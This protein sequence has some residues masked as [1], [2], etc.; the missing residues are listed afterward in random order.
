M[1]CGVSFERH[2]RIWCPKCNATICAACSSSPVVHV[3]RTRPTATCRSCAKLGCHRCTAPT[4]RAHRSNRLASSVES[5]IDSFRLKSTQE[6]FMPAD[7]DDEAPAYDDA[8][9]GCNAPFS[10]FR[11]RTK[12][13][14][15]DR[16]RC[17]KCLVQKPHSPDV[18]RLC[19]ECLYGPDFGRRRVGIDPTVV[20]CL[21]CDAAF[22]FFRRRHWCRRCGRTICSG[23]S[24][25][26]I[27]T[28][29]RRHPKCICKRCF[30]PK[31]FRLPYEL[32]Q[33]MME[34]V[35]QDGRLNAN[36]V[37][38]RFNRLMVMPFNAINRVDDYYVVDTKKDLLGEGAFGMVYA[39]VCR[40]TGEPRAIKVISKKKLFTYE[41]VK[42]LEREISI[43]MQLDH[44]N[45]VPLFETM[46][47]NTEVL[48]VM[49]QA[50]KFDLVDYLLGRHRVPE[51]QVIQ[52]AVQV[53]QFL[54]YLHA[55]KYTVHR[56]LKLDNVMMSDE[57][58]VLVRVIDFGLA[59]VVGPPPEVDRTD[60]ISFHNMA[61]ISSGD[62][63]GSTAPSDWSPL[64]HMTPPNPVRIPSSPHDTQSNH[65]A[66]PPVPTLPAASSSRSGGSPITL[67]QPSGP[68]K[69]RSRSPRRRD[70]SSAG[71]SRRSDVGV[72]C[73]PCG[74][75]R[76]C[77][78]EVLAVRSH[79]QKVPH[80]AVFKRDIFSLGVL[81]YALLCGR[82][83]YES[84]TVRQ[85]RREM[86]RPLS[87]RGGEDLS[88]DCKS[89][90]ASL[91]T[92]KP[93]Y[94][95]SAQSAL[96]HVWLMG[97]GRLMANPV[98]HN[99]Q[100]EFRRRRQLERDRGIEHD[101]PFMQL[102][103]EEDDNG[104]VVAEHVPLSGYFNRTQETVATS[105]VDCHW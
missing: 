58:N 70:S 77:A 89:F 27:S 21:V 46:Q 78:P 83:P 8:C 53:L 91:C 66:S 48:M 30:V 82:L 40:R 9:E 96:T 57:G 4:V 35:D 34:F 69:S 51:A 16:I 29:S 44:P 56:D 92:L 86:A 102:K 12:C 61:S 22:S 7:L 52:I 73:T 38:K 100:P 42:V 28:W 5:E 101:R 97:T 93:Y 50:G 45:T 64:P 90:I 87:F 72:L 11:Q 32:A 54:H 60:P 59:K 36:R 39:A 17:A 103:V 80:V 75:L 20:T 62:G 10:F 98:F 6:I 67:G 41:K 1:R 104:T 74:T 2:R 3:R 84:N 81:L 105:E 47:T 95:P 88:A 49:G 79:H 65:S 85:L 24:S 63:Q 19:G 76:Y 18:T 37:C 94:R 43:H 26:P 68:Q 71:G 25:T 23:C 15:C 14:Q 31:I 33:Y 55:D 99:I 13:A